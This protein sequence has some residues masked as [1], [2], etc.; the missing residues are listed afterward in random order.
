MD[1]H[2]LGLIS[3]AVHIISDSL[4]LLVGFISIVLPKRQK[5]VKTWFGYYDLDALLW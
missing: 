3:D 2:S 1:S 4:S 5:V